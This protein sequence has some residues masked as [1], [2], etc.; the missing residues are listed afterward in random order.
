MTIAEAEG[1]LDEWRRNDERRDL[2]VRAAR[3]A[4]ME[5][6]AISAHSGLSRPTVYKILGVG[7]GGK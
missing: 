7:P 5:I 4:G 1:Q 3:E 2:L 6:T